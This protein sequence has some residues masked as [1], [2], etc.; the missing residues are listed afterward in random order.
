MEAGRYPL[1]P[2]NRFGRWTFD[3]RAGSFS[4]ELLLSALVTGPLRLRDGYH[5]RASKSVFGPGA[6][7]EVGRLRNWVLFA[8]A[9]AFGL[10]VAFP[11]ERRGSSASRSGEEQLKSAAVRYGYH[12]WWVDAPFRLGY[13][14][15]LPLRMLRLK[16]HLILQ[17]RIMH[18]TKNLR[19]TKTYQEEKRKGNVSHPHKDCKLDLKRYRHVASALKTSTCRNPDAGNPDRQAGGEEDRQLPLPDKRG[20]TTLEEEEHE[21]VGGGKRTRTQKEIMQE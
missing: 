15:T 7:I 3:G 10:D 8:G 5:W 14:S 18:E 13:V 1:M 12:R 20:R 6:Q 2:I 17:N 4:A 11:G 19:F 16:E 21:Q 9:D